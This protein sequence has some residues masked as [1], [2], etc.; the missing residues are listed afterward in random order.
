MT[1]LATASISAQPVCAIIKTDWT[2]SAQ[3][4]MEDMKH[5]DR[6]WAET[7]YQ[8]E[9]LATLRAYYLEYLKGRARPAS[10]GTIDK[11]GKTLLSF[12]RALDRFSDPTTLASLTPHNVNRWVREQREAGMAEDGIASRLS[13]LKA[14][15][16]KYVWKHLEITTTDLLEKVPRI[17]PPLKAFPRL[18]PD[19]QEKIF[20]VYSAGTYEDVREQALLG[21]YLATG[22]RFK[23]ILELE[24]KDLNQISGEIR[25]IAKGGDEQFA[26][27]SPKALKLVR[28]YLRERPKSDSQRLWL[29]EDGNPLS[30]WGGQSVFRRLKGKTGITRLHPHLLRHTFAQ[31]ALEK[32]AERAAVQD[33]LGHK[34][35]AM[36]RRYAG[37]MRQVTAARLMPQYSPL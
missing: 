2:V 18:A 32:G 5:P 4:R 37:A 8:E 23:E 30:Y 17:N 11:Y 6:V 29:T 28:R 21:C 16:R 1:P 12:I 27:L 33:M 36:T 15:S 19:E 20:D 3:E 14:F 26:V 10:E 7:N 34:T 24:I 13:A 25:V 31:V 35:E 22:R 9:K